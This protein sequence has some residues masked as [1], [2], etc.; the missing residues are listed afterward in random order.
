M[1]GSM[2]SIPFALAILKSLGPNLLKHALIDL[3]DASLYNR[4]DLWVLSFG[5][6]SHERLNEKIP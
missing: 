3:T 2:V 5:T 6:A 4:F 1:N